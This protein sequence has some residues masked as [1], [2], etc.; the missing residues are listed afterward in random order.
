MVTVV[1]RGREVAGGLVTFL[2]RPKETVYMPYMSINKEIS[3][4]YTISDYLSW[5]TVKRAGEMGFEKVSFGY[6]PSNSNHPDFIKKQRF[7]CKYEG[8]RS[9]FFP[10]SST[11]K[12]ASSAY[13]MFRRFVAK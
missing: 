4:R 3:N 8:Y 1:S 10:T 2:Y 12:F 13:G 9:L 11:F 7:G 6:A 5:D